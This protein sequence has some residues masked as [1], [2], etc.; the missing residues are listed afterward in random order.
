MAE[1]V[2]RTGHIGAALNLLQENQEGL[3]EAPEIFARAE[4]MRGQVL[5]ET[6]ALQEG[7]ELFL[8]LDS[9]A[10]QETESASKAYPWSTMSFVAQIGL[11]DYGHASERMATVVSELK[12]QTSG[13]ALM[14][15][16]LRTMPLVASIDTTLRSTVVTQWPLAQ[17][18]HC[19]IPMQTVPHS[20]IEPRFMQAMAE[21]EG[22]LLDAARVN[23][24]AIVTEYGETPFRLLAVVYLAKLQEDM[25]DFI[26]NNTIDIWEDW[27]EP[28]F[29]ASSV[30]AS[31][32][33]EPVTEEHLVVAAVPSLV[34][35][36]Q[37]LLTP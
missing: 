5:L 34:A 14:E 33:E 26:T 32:T 19:L 27:S 11:G 2:A 36:A 37:F 8:H 30:E 1:N 25:Q 20:L 6:G 21:L 35:A 17:L 4:A 18:V 31:K 23:L 15:R 24:Q 3:R 10:Q 28:E 16:S 29:E 22:G 13:P 9:V 7:Y 12:S